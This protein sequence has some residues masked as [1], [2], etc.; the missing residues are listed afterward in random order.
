MYFFY[1]K[2]LVK[3]FFWVFLVFLRGEYLLFKVIWWVFNRFNFS[4]I[5]GVCTRGGLDGKN[6]GIF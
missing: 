5:Y 6:W 1:F 4:Y 2:R 3:L